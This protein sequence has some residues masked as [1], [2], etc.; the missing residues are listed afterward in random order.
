[1]DIF[2]NAPKLKTSAKKIFILAGSYAWACSKSFI[3]ENG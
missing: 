2:E 3:D 1:M